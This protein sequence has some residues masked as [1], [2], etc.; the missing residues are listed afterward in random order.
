MSSLPVLPLEPPSLDEETA[1]FDARTKDMEEF[2]AQS[3]FSGIKRPYTAASVV[4][5]Q[6]SLPITPLPGSLLADKLFAILTKAANEG[7]PVHTMGA[8]D[9]IQ[10]T[11]MARNQE[12]LYV[13]GWAA[14]SVLTTGTTK[15]VRILG[16]FLQGIYDICASLTLHMIEIIHILPSQTKC[17]A[18]SVLSNFMTRSITMNDF[19][20]RQ[21]NE[22]KCRLWIT[23]APSLLM[24]ILGG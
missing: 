3:R 16:T 20:L 1:Q 8:I 4:S 12:A 10:M 23:C 17:T 14:S 15:L 9:P 11:Q 19:L 7:R 21:P 2:F 24:Q 6:G 5:K 22:R 18:Y 13:S